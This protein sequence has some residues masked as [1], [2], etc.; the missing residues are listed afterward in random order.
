MKPI[1]FKI[2]GNEAN[3][4]E[5][6]GF[7]KDIVQTS[8]EHKKQ[9]RALAFA[10]LVYNFESPHVAKILEDKYYWNSLHR[11]AGHYLS[12]YYIHSDFDYLND[13][14]VYFSR[15]DVGKAYNH[16]YGYKT[17]GGP[18]DIALPVLKQF[19]NID[20]R[21]KLPALI[22]F[23]IDDQNI[24]DTIFIELKEQQIEASFLELKEILIKSVNKL[25]LIKEE[26]YQN[27]NAIFRE[28]KTGLINL[29][30][31]KIFRKFKRKIS[32]STLLSLI[33]SS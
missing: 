24:S 29:K 1:V 13:K 15:G 3:P 31:K 32:F 11:I 33:F 21:I 8:I 25:K 12:I 9:K 20:E 16:F 28:L 14:K 17:Q 10:F 27:S 18:S 30:H 4:L 19:F 6:E 7:L 5:T 22:F 2:D 23:Q 26:N